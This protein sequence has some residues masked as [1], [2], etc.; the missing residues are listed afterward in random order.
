MHFWETHNFKFGVFDVNFQE[1]INTQEKKGIY[2]TQIFTVDT[3]TLVA[4]VLIRA[5]MRKRYSGWF[6]IENI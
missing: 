1:S 4:P 2:A 5:N 6:H 3:C